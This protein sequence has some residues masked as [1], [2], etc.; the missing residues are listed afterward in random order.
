MSVSLMYIHSTFARACVFYLFHRLHRCLQGLAWQG[1]AWV[2]RA[3]HPE[4]FMVD[5]V[6]DV[7]WQRLNPNRFMA[8]MANKKAM[9]AYMGRAEFIEHSIFEVVPNDYI[10]PYCTSDSPVLS[11]PGTILLSFMQQHA[12]Q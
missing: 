8:D 12:A 7:R 6:A 1:R 11:F 3:R 10:E 2:C 4:A 9:V 5:A